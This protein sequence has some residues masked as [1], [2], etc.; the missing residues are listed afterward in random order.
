[1]IKPDILADLNFYKT[2]DGGRQGATPTNFFGCVISIDQNNFD[3]R[4]LLEQIGSI[5]P[6]ECKRRVPIKFLSSESALNKLKK[7]SQF[8]I[9]DGQIIGKG[10]VIEIINDT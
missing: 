3:A 9:R 4:L 10:T 6:G 2:E 1:M 8:L 5:S 7:N